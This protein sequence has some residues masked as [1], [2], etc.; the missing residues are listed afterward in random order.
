M[1]C[2]RAR[3][4]TGRLGQLARPYGFLST[5]PPTRCGLA[6]FNSAL[7]A[8]LNGGH[9]IVRGHRRRRR[10]TAPAGG[11]AHLDGPRR[12]GGWADAAE[13]LNRYD[14][15][16]VQHEYGIYP[17][18]DGQ[19]LL[20]LL[21]A[22]RCRAS[23]CCTPSWSGR[24]PARRCCWRRSPDAAGAIV[25]MTGTA[26][27]RLLAGYRVDPAKVSVIPARDRRPHARPRPAAGPAAPADLG[28]DRPRQGHRVGGAGARAPGAIWRRRTRS[29]GGP[30]PRC[31]NCRARPT[32]TA[33]TRSPACWASP[34]PS[35]TTRST[36]TRSR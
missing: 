17:G 11:G 21:R 24:P 18:A 35:G 2:H 22:W 19:D 30:T 6:T 34:P 13:A 5:H 36:G 26:R 4:P 1:A 9:G 32:A 3:A 31:W 15:A 29:P 12:P 23:W 27:D 7:A 25:L 16:I 20:P 28:A 33:C 14:V 10:R 8:H